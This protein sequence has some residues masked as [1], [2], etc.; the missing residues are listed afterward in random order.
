MAHTDKHYV[1]IGAYGGLGQALCKHCHQAGAKLSVLG[2]EHARL[3]KIANQYQA[4]AEVVDATDVEAVLAAV[5]ACRDA[6][7]PIDG[8]VNCVGSILL[9]PAHL[10][11]AREWQQ[12]LQTNL[13]SAF[14]AVHA[15]SKT[16]TELGGSVV[17]V[18]TAACLIGLPNHEAISAAKA[19][20]NGLVKAAAASYASKHLR[21]N[22]VAP[23]LV[24]TPLSR[25]I[26]NNPK[27]LAISLAGHPLGRIG[28]PDD[29]A[30]MIQFLL[31]ADNDWLT[32]QVIA[33]DGGLA[34][35]K[36]LGK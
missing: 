26:T 15:A 6:V 34:A 18:S 24:D 13:T 28:K 36:M 23:G 16:M 11:T 21:F 27:A 35:I 5:L 10:L 2:R 8:F 22:A 4:H 20:V 1:I 12:T 19:G 14:A 32:G 30:H 3:T 29:I 9:K 31:D 7:G 25:H 33:V 17:L